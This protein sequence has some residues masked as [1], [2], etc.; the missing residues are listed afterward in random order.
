MDEVF[1][2]M[3]TGLHEL[4]QVQTV[5]NGDS[6]PSTTAIRDRTSSA[7]A[8]L[9][10]VGLVYAKGNAVLAMFE[11]YL[12]AATFQKGVRAYLKEHE[13]GN[14]TAADLWRALDRAS[15]TNVSAAMSTFLDQPGVPFVRVVPVAGGVRVTQ[16]RAT[17]YGVSQPAMRWKLPVTLKWSDGKTVR[18]QRLLLEEESAVVKLPAKPAWVMPNGGGHGYYA[19]SVP[20][21]WMAALSEHANT[22]LTPD[23]R[24]AF[25]GNLA[26]LMTAGDVHGDTYLASLAHFGRDPEPQVV[27]STMEALTAV[28]TAFVPDSL[29]DLFAVYVRRTLSPALERIGYEK[30]AGEDEMVATTRG[31]LL[32]WVAGRGR[33]EKALA[34][35]RAA[36]KRYLADSSAVDP[37]IADAALSLA[38]RNGDAALFETYRA[39]FEASDV[40]AIRR[41][42][43]GAL[44]AFEDPSLTTRALEYMLTDKVR[45]T[46][47]F[48]L[49]RGM[50]GRDEASQQRL[51]EAMIANYP[52]IAA[53]VPPPAL[54]FM[55]MM[56]SG[57][58][59]ERLAATEAFFKDPAHASPGVEQSV[60]RVRDMVR[61]C[62]SLRER[63]GD[64]VLRYMRGFA[65]N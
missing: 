15:G 13:W 19:W 39:R 47:M 42:Y 27:S 12:G 26:L 63:D 58:S 24:V 34:F 38:A 36:A 7:A 17:P 53:R 9:Q 21:E 37:G 35:A 60:E 46:E 25:L 64:R 32:R 57:C 20:D 52:Q 43:L 45:P 22:V 55:P 5:K 29:A 62:L 14:A 56:G 2:A 30:R 8:G 59:A 49:V 4:Q 44:G 51:F 48:L 28:R 65:T 3:K 10:N 31:D 6:Q 61:T 16:S 54:R 1:P 33:D 18:T 50:A 23:E 40:P 41:R 11:H